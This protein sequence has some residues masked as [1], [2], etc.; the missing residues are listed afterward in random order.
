[1]NI[2]F[3][4]GALELC[5]LVLLDKKDYYGYELVRKVSD[6][7]EISEGTIYPLMRRLS[8]EEYVTT[9]LQES[10]E[11]PSRKYYRLTDK[12]QRNLKEMLDDWNEF[13]QAV[14]YLID[15]QEGDKDE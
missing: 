5:V 1:M 15:N 10:S 8:K 9:Y 3:K 14:N 4:K 2:Q 13:T 11:G 6:Q 7:I 12:G